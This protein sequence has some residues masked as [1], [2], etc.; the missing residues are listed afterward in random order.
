[1]INWSFQPMAPRSW[2]HL[3]AFLPAVAFADPS[4]TD[5][6]AQAADPRALRRRAEA[7]LRQDKKASE[8]WVLMGRAA[9]QDGKKKKA[10]KYFAKALKRDPHGADAYYWRGKIFEE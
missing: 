5:V 9:Y 10:L 2:I 8:P 6:S 1:M 7:L 3:L 4:S